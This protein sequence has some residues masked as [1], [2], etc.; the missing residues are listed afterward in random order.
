MQTLGAPGVVLFAA[1]EELHVLADDSTVRRTTS[2][3]VSALAD[4]PESLL[5]LAA[6]VRAFAAVNE[7]ERVSYETPLGER[8]EGTLVEKCRYGG[9]VLAADEN[10]VGL[11]FRKIKPTGA[12]P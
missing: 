8:T 1:D 2:H 6:D 3:D 9:L 12:R 11:G 4:P 7:G 10:V 5:R